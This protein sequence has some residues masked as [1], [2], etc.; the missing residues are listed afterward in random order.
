MDRDIFL[1]IETVPAYS[2]LAPITG[3]R[4]YGRDCMFGTGHE[5]G[6]LTAGEILAAS[7]DALVYREYLDPNY[8]IPNTAPIIA[9][10]RNE[11]PWDRRVPGAVL[12]AKPGER[13]HI[14]VRNADPGGC[15]SFHLHGLRYGIDS[16]GAW[17]FGLRSHDGRRSD[18][19]QPGQTWTY[20]YEASEDTIGP[21]AFHDHVRGIGRNI[22]RGLFGGLIVRDPRAAC[23][24]HE[25]PLFLH[26]M[27]GISGA[28][29]ESGTLSTGASFSFTFPATPGSV[30]YHCAIHGP[31]MAG[32][33]H[34]VTGG[35]ASA[36]VVIGDNFFSPALVT[37]GP[38]G[39]VTWTNHGANDHIVFAPG[40]GAAQYCLNGRTYVGNT[41]TIV[42]DVGQRLRWYLFNLDVGDV[43]HNFHP[44]A[45][46][47][48]LPTPPGTASDV[49]PLSPAQSFVIDTKAPEP[50]RLPCSL[51]ELQCDPPPDACRVRVRGDFLVHCHLEEH[52]MAGLAGLVRSRRHIWITDEMRKTLPY[53]LP[54][55]DDTDECAFV[56]TMRCKG[57]T[58]MP[59]DG[60]GP[61]P[62]D[63]SKAATQ[64]LWEVLPIDSRVLAVHAA[65]MHT[66]KVLFFAGSG[67][68]PAKLA[69]H[70]FRSVVWDYENGTFVV[71]SFTPD[72]VF[73]A[74]QAFLPD[75]RLLV[76]GGTEQYDP[77]H[78]LR[79]T[80][81]FDPIT[82]QWTRLAD[83]ADGRWYPTLLALGDGRIFALSGLGTGGADNRVPEAYDRFVGWHALPA[84]PFDWPLYPHM[85]LLRNGKLL[86]AGGYMG[87]AA[88]AVP[89]VI[90]PVTGGFSAIPATAQYAQR[91]QAASVMLPPAQA[92]RFLTVGGGD[93]ATADVAIVDMTAA[94]PT[95]APAPSA[96]FARMHANAV[97][98]PDRTVHVS[99]GSR[100]GEEPMTAE[101]T[102]ELYHPATGTWTVAAAA[103]VPR[104]YHSVA[105]LLPDGRVITAGSNPH[106]T[107]DELRLELYHPP[108]LFRGPRPSIDYAA[109]Q[110][111][112]GGSFDL[113]TPEATSIKWVQLI[114]PMATTHSVDT[115][116]RLVDLHFH[117]HDGC[118]LSVEAATEP[119]LAPPGWYMLFIVDDQNVPSVAKWI[120]LT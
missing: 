67:N 56:D 54:F 8:T 83:M 7:L 88:G 101:L 117:R 77:F 108:Y 115:E 2:P 65:L 73:C 57:T 18:E 14:H 33:V 62:I 28:S 32:Q 104:L 74:G 5:Y 23:A 75:G 103:T 27:A 94:T 49:H 107:D 70:D 55:D 72:D 92:Q 15:H 95:F 120:H 53:E 78:G 42:A 118:R 29:F 100:I 111:S 34:V 22:N 79:S 99:G 30:A 45:A 43:W 11:P 87:G 39:T 76:A 64:G 91:D 96:N 40:G 61:M 80:W 31:S 47:W 116:Q 9:A 36:N 35:P 17:P 68:D 4:R 50:V 25:I 16:D 113:R 90:D 37:I 114:R 86:Y 63:M 41:P 3:S 112:Y 71:P 58:A 84:S 66:G 102:S 59:A 6:R 24:N 48:Q 44:H 46:R 12:Y 106:R 110:W 19:I 60:I 51:E 10:D 26:Q 97:I 21:W 105:L 85:F 52:M 119:T 98:L 38:G 81:L 82:L 93:P 69:A 20:V 1:Q 13:L 109:S 89:G